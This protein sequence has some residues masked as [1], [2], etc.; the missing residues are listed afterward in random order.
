[1]DN[2]L[3]L[4]LSLTLTLTLTGRQSPTN[5]HIN[6]FV[7]TKFTFKTLSQRTQKIINVNMNKKKMRKKD[8][9]L[10][11]LANLFSSI[12][13]SRTSRL[14][15]RPIPICGYDARKR[16]IVTLDCRIRRRRRRRRKTRDMR[17][18]KKKD[19]AEKRVLKSAE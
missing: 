2:P 11:A 10:C 19:E 7:H 15:L 14:K 6:R 18:E 16:K 4:F 1:M 3:L 8:A 17:R 5:W 12:F 9:S 13:L